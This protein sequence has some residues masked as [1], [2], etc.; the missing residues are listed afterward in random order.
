MM[1]DYITKW[2]AVH[3]SGDYSAESI[4]IHWWGEPANHRSGTTF[5]NTARFLA[6]DNPNDSSAHFIVSG[7]EKKLACL[8]DLD[9]AAWH[10]GN[11]TGNHRSVGIECRPWDAKTPKTEIELEMQAAAYTVALIW[12]WRP[13][14]KGQKLKGHRD[15]YNTAC[16]GNYYQRLD[17]LRQRALELY[18]QVDPNRPGKLIVNNTKPK[19]W[20]DMAN[21]DD[22]RKIVREEIANRVPRVTFS[23]GEV[24]KG[25]PPVTENLAAATRRGHTIGRQARD[26]VTRVEAKLDGLI[27]ELKKTEACKTIDLAAIEQTVRDAVRDG[28]ADVTAEHVAAKLDVTVKEAPDVLAD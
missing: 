17:D 11:W 9:H 22:L 27:R 23:V 15:W 8:V 6:S 1:L 10:S 14:L 12:H 3:Q 21:E 26:R 25:T 7:V 20:F 18:Q 24:S 13:K 19:D 28:T 5:D 4:T 16:P 2:T